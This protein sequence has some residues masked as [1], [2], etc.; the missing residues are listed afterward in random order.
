MS[1][2]AKGAASADARALRTGS[3]SSI[4]STVGVYAIAVLIGTLVPVKFLVSFE[5]LILFAA[6]S[7]VI[8][9][10]LNAIRFSRLRQRSDLLL[11]ITWGWLILTIGAYFL[12][13]LSGL[14]Q[15]LWVR[16][17]WFSEND[18]LHIGLIIWM[19]YIAWMVAPKVEDLPDIHEN[20]YNPVESMI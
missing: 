7:I 12:Y 5:M 2:R 9:L 17:I 13:Y 16:G 3:F 10:L 4:F 15:A 18:V 8:F 19:I 20:R 1:E 14:T 6:P 11:L